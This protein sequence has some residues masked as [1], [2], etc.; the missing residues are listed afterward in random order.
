MWVFPEKRGVA[1]SYEQKQFTV[2][3][4][5]GKWLPIVSSRAE[6][7][8]DGEGSLWIGQDAQFYVSRLEPGQSVE[9]ALAEGRKA[10]L[11]VIAGSPKLNGEPLGTNDSVAA[12][13]VPSLTLE[14]GAEPVELLMIDLP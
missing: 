9:H 6:H 11:F 12:E 1:P 8:R 4:R 5:A 3:D 14:A 2:A 7:W 13:Q 10:Y